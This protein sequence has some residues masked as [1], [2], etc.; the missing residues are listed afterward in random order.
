ML[1]NDSP[2]KFCNDHWSQ[3]IHPTTFKPKVNFDDKHLL[4]VV[5]EWLE[6]LMSSNKEVLHF[7]QN[8]PLQIGLWLHEHNKWLLQDVLLCHCQQ[9]KKL[10]AKGSLEDLSVFCPWSHNVMSFFMFTREEIHSKEM[11]QWLYFP[12]DDLMEN[13]SNC[14]SCSGRHCEI[15]STCVWVLWECPYKPITFIMQFGASSPCIHVTLF[16]WMS[17]RCLG[18]T[19]FCSWLWVSSKFK[20]YDFDTLYIFL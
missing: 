15:N 7:V 18:L 3:A 5:C 12:L 8:N 4:G 11:K 1:L 13:F 19:N 20:S 16:P 6:R 2:Y 9:S 10:H 14:C 17:W